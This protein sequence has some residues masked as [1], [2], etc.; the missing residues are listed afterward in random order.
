VKSR[1]IEKLE[2]LDRFMKVLQRE[3]LN[4]PDDACAAAMSNIMFRKLERN[5]RLST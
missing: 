4:Q 2:H 5:F 1:D 3:H